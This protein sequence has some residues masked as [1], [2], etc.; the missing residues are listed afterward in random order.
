MN[1]FK[2][3]DGTTDEFRISRQFWIFV[4]ATIILAIITLSGWFILTHK[5]EKLR[6]KSRLSSQD[7]PQGTE[8]DIELEES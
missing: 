6:Q 3:D 2:F 7:T 1:L 5:E 4:V 8:Q